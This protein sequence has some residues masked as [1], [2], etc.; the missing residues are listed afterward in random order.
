MNNARL[1][2]SMIIISQKLI[3]MTGKILVM[4]LLVMC[5]ACGNQ[6]SLPRLPRGVEKV[7]VIDGTEPPD[8]MWKGIPGVKVWLVDD[9]PVATAQDA[10]AN[11]RGNAWGWSDDWYWVIVFRDADNAELWRVPEGQ[12]SRRQWTIFLLDLQVNHPDKVGSQKPIPQGFYEY[13]HNFDI[14]GYPDYWMAIPKEDRPT[15][16]EEF[17]HMLEDL[18]ARN[19]PDWIFNVPLP[20]RR[21]AMSKGQGQE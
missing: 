18:E 4:T 6:T 1:E 10:V 14:H 9:V 20:T 8:E 11:Y 16:N 3:Y 15:T 2:M 5:Q 19:M 17:L 13:M 12:I 7:L 21:D